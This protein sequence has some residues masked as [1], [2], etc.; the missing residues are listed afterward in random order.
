MASYL[1][2]NASVK[3]GTVTV[4]NLS[5]WTLDLSSDPIVQAVFGSTWDKTHGLSTTSWSGSFS[6][7]LDISDTTGQEVL[8]D[9]FVNGTLVDDLRLYINSTTYWAPDTATDSAAGCY[10]T[11]YSVNTVQG[12]VIKVSVSFTGTGPVDKF[13]A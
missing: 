12:D 3:I 7:L 11:S 1:G 5:E 6:G 10:I 4:A 13:T 9:A 2:R 8:S